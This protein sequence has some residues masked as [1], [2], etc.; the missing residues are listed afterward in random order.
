MY[1]SIE[2]ILQERCAQAEK[3]FD[4]LQANLNP[5]FFITMADEHDAL[6]NLVGSLHTLVHNRHL[7]LADQPGQL[8]QA[9]LSLP[10]SL[11]QSFSQLQEQNISYAE[12]SH[13][14]R[15]VPGTKD[16][17]EI[18]RFEF[19]RKPHRE[20]AAAGIIRIPRTIKQAIKN[21]MPAAY[22]DFAFADFDQILRMLWLNNERY[23]RISPPERVARIISLYQQV[24]KHN[25]LYLDV[26]NTEDVTHHQESRLLFAVGNPP[27]GGFLAQV[28][29]ILNRF[30]ISIRR[31]YCLNVSNGVTPYFLATLYVSTRQGDLVLKES[32]FYQELKA[33]LYNTQILANTG[34]VYTSFLVH[35]VMTGPE[36]SLT[37][38]LIAF[39][40]G[41]LAHNR[42]EQFDLQ[43]IKRAFYHNPD[44]ALQLTKLFFLR[45]HPSEE[46]REVRYGRAY[47][48]VKEEIEGYNTGHRVLDETRKTIFFTALLLIHYTLKTNFFVPEKHALAFRLDPAYLV[49]MGD[50]FTSD[51][52]AGEPFRVT[53]FYGRYGAGYHVGF[54]D[55][56]RGG[57]RTVICRTA[58]DFLT[59]AD[60][61][62]REVY[63]LAHTQNLKNKDIYEGGSKMGVVLDVSDIEDQDLIT[64]RL[65]KLQYGFVNA[66]LDIFVTRNGRVQHPQVVDYYGEDEPIE[67][68]PDENMHDSMIELIARQSVKRGYLLGP[69]LISSKEVGI[70]HKQYG[71]TSLGV[72]TFAEITMAE[73]GVDMRHDPFTVKIT[74]GPNGDVAGN[75]I[76]LLLARCPWVA[77][78]LVVAGSGAA[79]DPR[80]LDGQE[81]GRLALAANIDDFNPDLLSPGGFILFRKIRR[82]EGLVELFRKLVRTEEGV[83]EHWITPD[84]FHRE[85][86]GLIFSVA[87]D[88]FIPAGGR[89]ETIDSHNW[90]RLFTA[91]GEATC[92]AIVE[93]AN[94]FITPA[95]RQEI[96]QRGV[97]VIRDA[98]ANKC[99]VISSSYE[100]IANLLLSEKEFLRH[101]ETY[102][103][104][105]LGILEKRARD[106]AQL[107]FSRYREAGGSILYTEIANSI[108]AE[109]NEH[110]NRLFSFFQSRPDLAADAM[111]R[112][113]ILA[114]LP[115]FISDN[116]K[117]R[118]RIRK[119]PPKYHYAI[120]ASELASRIVY[121]GEW[122]T[123]FENTL[124]RYVKKHF[125]G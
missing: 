82:Q 46:D 92:R 50:E 117:Y 29:E 8:I 23:I 40:H 115:R 101:K 79:Y 95:A 42:P 36:A 35:R 108:S 61:L 99:G 62:F 123:D 39:C 63:V 11:Y 66:F 71:V 54:A 45:F 3:N 20:I 72:I 55:I 77:I 125:S 48:H 94:S 105:V 64:Q 41:N 44:L 120:L 78:T 47:A 4:W 32:A 90:Q 104:D 110:Y 68:G 53:F 7:V 57:W 5:Y 1:V 73:L 51:L 121:Q 12:V 59:T 69:A 113:V 2:G 119:L 109:I 6:A 93:G 107:L 26:E 91:R 22:P 28:L 21:V 33:E 16:P 75:A 56:A 10:G 38:A 111:F 58:D 25:G 116:R 34:R 124:K 83:E 97:I 70:N 112:P 114:H 43:E 30:D 37:N 65:Y 118:L 84:E 49:A 67:L 18:Q 9:S 76:R 86:D 87:A 88:L 85:F 106:E 52:P 100:I 98:A 81:M 102:V 17:L 60:T 96:Q 103:A 27:E 24:C 13:S 74:G 14:Y 15:P 89:P 31:A 80:G 19:D 122:E